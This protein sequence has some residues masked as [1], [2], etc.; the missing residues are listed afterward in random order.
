[1]PP[2]PLLTELPT[3]LVSSR[4][5]GFRTPY[6]R[7]LKRSGW[8]ELSELVSDL[9]DLKGRALLGVLLGTRSKTAGELV[10]VL[11]FWEASELAAPTYRIILCGLVLAGG[12]KPP[13]DRSYASFRETPPPEARFPGRQPLS[14][15]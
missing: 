2:L 12:G 6:S 3:R 5:P 4:K 9:V 14:A 1:M 10:Q 15:T 11:E 13:P 8:E 7:K